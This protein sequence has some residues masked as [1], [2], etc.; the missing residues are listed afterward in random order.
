MIWGIGRFFSGLGILCADGSGS[1]VYLAIKVYP[2]PQTF[3]GLYS[4]TFGKKIIYG[5][6]K[7][8]APY[9]PMSVTKKPATPALA[10]GHRKAV[11]FFLSR[12]TEDCGAKCIMGYLNEAIKDS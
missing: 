8:K 1:S 3:T 6:P 11:C 9:L 10:S 12:E 4:P 7:T 5:I 2:M